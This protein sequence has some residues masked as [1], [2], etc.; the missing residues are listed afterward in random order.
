MSYQIL[1]LKW[2]PKSFD[3]IVG[4]SHIT[5]T[6]NNAITINRLAQAFLFSGPRGVGKTTTARVLASTINGLDSH[7]TCLDIIELDGAS[8]RGIDEIR[9]IRESVK[10]PPSSVEYKVYIIDEAHMLTEQAFNALL[11]TLEEPP[12]HVIF[13]LATTDP[14]KMPQTI[15]SRTQRYDFMRISSEVIVDRLH[16]ILKK[17]NI[18]FEENAIELISQKSDGSM[19]DALSMLDQIIAYSDKII[20]IENLRS[21]IGLI[22]QEDIYLV[23][24]SILEQ[25]TDKAI[26]L[27]HSILDSGVSSKLF[28]NDL[29]GFL[30]QCMLLKVNK[31]NKRQYISKHLKEKIINNLNFEIKDILK[32]IKLGFALSARMKFIE[33]NK[34]S[35]EVLVVDYISLIASN[36]SYDKF[37]DNSNSKSSVPN[38]KIDLEQDEINVDRAQNFEN[39]HSVSGN[40]KELKHSGISEPEISND[41]TNNDKAT[42]NHEHIKDASDGM[43]ENQILPSV[44]LVKSKWNEIIQLLD[45]Q[46]SKLSS[47]FEETNAK[48][49]KNGILILQLKNG[50]QFIK[51]VLESDKS[52]LINVINDVCGFSIDINVEMIESNENIEIAA[53]KD[54]DTNKDEK[55]HPLLDD[56]INMFKGKIIS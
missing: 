31:N 9:E 29:I 50:N 37:K 17:E 30:N 41:E 16:Y 5:H 12:K 2:R 56:A 4:Q 15:L 6:L 35:I 25:N 8:N 11:K 20:N 23:C 10:F 27:Y 43:S 14:Q 36:S 42:H 24:K 22:D 55:N 44:N 19:R 26:D 33:N 39:S 13:I 32:M 7:E 1:S 51:K 18:D 40:Q 34:V 48:E 49:I 53:E 46:N 54:I 21:A 28:I 52:I 47:F 3:Q 45:K 38:D